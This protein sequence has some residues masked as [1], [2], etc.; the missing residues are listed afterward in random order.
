VLLLGG[1]VALASGGGDGG[2]DGS[3]GVATVDGSDGDEAVA[4]DGDGDGGRVD[5]SELQDAML[6]YAECMRD[7]GIDMPDPE[8][9]GDGAGGS[10]V[11]QR[12]GPGDDGGGPGPESEELQ[13][14][15]EECGE[16]I[17]EIRG[18][19]PQLSPEEVAERQDQLVAMAQCM[20]DRGYD[21]PD[22][23]VSS[24]GGVQIQM[25]DAGPTGVGDP[26]NDQFPED[27]EECSEQAGL[28][29]GPM[30]RRGGSA[31]GSDGDG[32][33]S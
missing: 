17:E 31:G 27:Q 1:G 25:R 4:V 32:S 19:M 24:D 20:R 21:M 13:A 11:I 18:E 5:E 29:N 10:M 7:H 14:A 22:P 6:E 2:D 26:R 30:G 9:D 3:D 12:G 8:F 15:D 23:Q 33:T 28:E 16:V